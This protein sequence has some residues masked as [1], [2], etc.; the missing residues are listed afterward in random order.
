[1]DRNFRNATPLVSLDYCINPEREKDFRLELQL[2]GYK[3]KLMLIHPKSLDRSFEEFNCEYF[4]ILEKY[5]NS[6]DCE[7]RKLYPTGKH[8]PYNQYSNNYVI[9]KYIKIS[10][11]LTFDKIR[12]LFCK[13]FEEVR[14][15]GQKAEKSM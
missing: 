1:M 8:G 5:R 12:D 4:K 7:D 14:K 3:L 15:F 9:Y 2:Q 10:K 6:D 13:T 11:D